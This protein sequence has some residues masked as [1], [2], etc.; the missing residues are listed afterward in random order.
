MI[1]K[2]IIDENIENTKFQKR[3]NLAK[4]DA[5]AMCAVALIN[6]DKIYTEII[7]TK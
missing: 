4:A 1:T 6:L 5:L 2:E 3:L 7:N